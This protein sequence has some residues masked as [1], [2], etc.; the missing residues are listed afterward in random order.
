MP[1]NGLRT[2][3]ET[4]EL[5]AHGHALLVAGEASLLRQLPRG[6]WIGGTAVSFMT[7]DGGVTDHARIFVTD[8]SDVASAVSVHRYTAD[9]L[10]RIGADYPAS[11][12]SVVIVPG[13]STV[14]T[15][16]AKEVQ[17]YPGV[18]NSPLLGWVAAVDVKEIGKQRPMVFAGTGEARADDAAVLHVQLK[19]GLLAELDIINLFRQGDGDPIV[20]DQEGFA[21][22]GECSISGKRANLAHYIKDKGIDTKLPLIADYSGALINVSIQSVDPATGEVHFY[23]PVFP[24]IEYRFAM[25]VANYVQAFEEAEHI[26]AGGIAFSCNCILNYLYAELQGKKTSGFSGPIT[27]GEIAYMLLNQTLVYLKVSASQ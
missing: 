18:F 20:F 9:E 13:G 19:P 11:G 15:R 1:K 4:A 8:L 7:E 6:N 14:H 24:G 2:V 26:D 21:S 27:F 10:S 17:S 22:S 25:P 3:A 5:I 16:F 12:F 23:A